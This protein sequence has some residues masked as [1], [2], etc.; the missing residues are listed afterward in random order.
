MQPD[1]QTHTLLTL[2]GYAGARVMITA[3]LARAKCRTQI[4]IGF[5]DAVTPGPIQAKYPVLIADFAAPMLRT[6]P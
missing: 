2:A 3:E 5:G 1:T 4:D 6:Y